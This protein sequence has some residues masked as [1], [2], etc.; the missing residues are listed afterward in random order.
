MLRYKKFLESKVCKQKTNGT[1]PLTSTEDM[2]GKL[3][4]LELQ[5]AEEEITRQVQKST[6]SKVF[7]ALG[8]ISPSA[9]NRLKKTQQKVGPLVFKLNPK[10]RSG[11]LSVDGRLESAPVDKDFEVSL[12]LTQRSPYNKANYLATRRV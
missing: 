2:V 1:T 6:F 5:K 4:I 12:H 9:G 11:L 10:L 8:N 7:E 3:T